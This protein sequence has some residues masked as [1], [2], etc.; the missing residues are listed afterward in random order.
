LRAEIVDDDWFELFKGKRASPIVAF[1]AQVTASAYVLPGVP[2]FVPVKVMRA[3]AL[4]SW[5]S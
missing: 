1:T 5:A 2:M 3:P 4:P